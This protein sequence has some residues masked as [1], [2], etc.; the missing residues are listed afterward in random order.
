MVEFY[1][2]WWPYSNHSEQTSDYFFGINDVR[3][4]A[5]SVCIIWW[6]NIFCW[7]VQLIPP[8]NVG[9]YLKNISFNSSRLKITKI[10]WE[11]CDF[12]GEIISFASTQLNYYLNSKPFSFV[13]ELWRKKMFFF[14]WVIA[15]TTALPPT[16]LTYICWI[17]TQMLRVVFGIVSLPIC[18]ILQIREKNGL[19]CNN[20]LW[21]PLTLKKL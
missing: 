3:T 11:W 14:F 2:T 13:S 9:F 7:R 16:V 18:I 6:W 10:T 5:K 17:C 15:T 21:C 19:V 4:V 12:L 20:A 8:K 1:S